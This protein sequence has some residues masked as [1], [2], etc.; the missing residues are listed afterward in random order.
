MKINSMVSCWFGRSTSLGLLIFLSLVV[1][2]C[3]G[4]PRA[5]VNGK[6]VVNGQPVTEGSLTFA[7]LGSGDAGKPGSPSIGQIKPDGTFALGTAK[8]SDGAV[9]G[10]HQVLY[11]APVPE[12]P[13]WDGYGTPPPMKVSPFSG[14]VPKESEVEVKAGK[15]EITIELVPAPPQPANS[16]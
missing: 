9:I 4:P 15:N 7:P 11:T 16:Q 8:E 10:R 2:G 5:K 12:G 6:V 14:F 1:A 13:D 3:G